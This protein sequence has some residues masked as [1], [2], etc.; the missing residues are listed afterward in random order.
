LHITDPRAFDPLRTAMHML[1]S[2]WRRWPE[3]LG[4]RSDF[5]LLT[6]TDRIREG[7]LAGLGAEQ[8]AELW[9]AEAAAFRDSSEGV[10]MY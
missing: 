5:E 2:A 3:Q 1:T 9:Q 6:G 8:I 4:L 7:L 10:F